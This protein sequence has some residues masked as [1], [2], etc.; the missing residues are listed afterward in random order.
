MGSECVCVCERERERVCCKTCTTE[1]HFSNFPRFFAVT[2][3]RRIQVWHAPGHT[4]NFAP[5]SLYRSYPGQYD[6]TTCID[7]SHDSKYEQ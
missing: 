5:F 3:G 7:W 1:F 6:D 4:P 2:H